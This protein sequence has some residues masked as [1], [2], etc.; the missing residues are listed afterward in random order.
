MD[1]FRTIAA[2]TLAAL[3]LSTLPTSAWAQNFPIKPIRILVGAIAGS[4]SDVRV[5]QAAQKLNEARGQPV[6]VDNRPGA[7][8]TIA[9]KLAA[10]AAPDGYTLLG[11]SINNVLNDL[12]IASGKLRALAV[13][14]AKR[15][16]VA[17]DLATMAEA[18]LPGVEASGWT[19][20]CAPAG[21][22][23]P[24]INLMHRELVKALNDRVIRDQMI[25]TGANPGGERPDEFAAFIRAETAKWGKVIKDAGISIQ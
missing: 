14:D 5:R 24:V 11:C 22:P 17:P 12:Y 19:A 8:G 13:A 3:T 7:S 16:A 1:N 15:L 2:S 6:I 4:P 18:G 25:S 10:K 21:V 23:Q 20:I 9:A